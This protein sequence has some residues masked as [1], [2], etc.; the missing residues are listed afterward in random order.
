MRFAVHYLLVLLLL[1]GYQI[2]PA[3]SMKA[4]DKC[5]TNG[6]V[7]VNPDNKTQYFFCMDKII[8]LGNCVDGR[9]FD[10]R[11]YQCVYPSSIT[12]AEEKIDCFGRDYQKFVDPEDDSIYYLCV[13]NQANLMRCATGSYFNTD[14]G[15]CL[16]RPNS[17]CASG[18]NDILPDPSG[19]CRKFLFCMEGE[20]HTQTCPH[21]KYFHPETMMCEEGTVAG[22]SALTGK[23][24]EMG[25]TQS[26]QRDCH[27]FN[28]CD[29][30]T[31]LTLICPMNYYFNPTGLYCEKTLPAACKAN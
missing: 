31:W 16:S 2:I 15:K 9:I 7:A 8:Y 21:G 30:R 5:I 28:Y 29:G 14:L 10:E 18:A 4:G 24:S 23:C 12:G 26:I 17:L 6:A 1:T 3:N 19:N 13:Y 20:A 22:C 11:I 25:R 27:V